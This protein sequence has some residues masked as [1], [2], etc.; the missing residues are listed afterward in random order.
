MGTDAVQA[1]DW[2]GPILTRPVGSGSGV[3][4]PAPV[5]GNKPRGG[6]L[7]SARNWL[8]GSVE[9]GGIT[10]DRAAGFTRSEGVKGRG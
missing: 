7:G 3:T 1:G 10:L 4:E 2:A 5:L 8:A 9:L 6:P